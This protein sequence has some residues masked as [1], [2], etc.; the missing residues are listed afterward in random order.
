[1]PDED[2]PK[3]PPLTQV[4]IFEPEDVMS[5][6][7]ADI[8]RVGDQSAWARKA[9]IERTI[10]NQILNGH[11]PPTISIIEALGLRVAIVSGNRQQKKPGSR[12]AWFGSW[13]RKK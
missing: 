6:L 1:M 9:G 11:K 4:R 5:L 3:L 8:E 12:R 10:V 2:R 13:A 7:R